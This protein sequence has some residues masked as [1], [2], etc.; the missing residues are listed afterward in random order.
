[1]LRKEQNDL[2]TQ[3]G[4][5]TP[6]GQMFRSHWLPALLAASCSSMGA[7]S[8]IRAR[9]EELAAVENPW[10]GAETYFVGELHGGG[11]PVLVIDDP[12]ECS[13]SGVHSP[14]T[15]V[16]ASSGTPCSTP[17]VPSRSTPRIRANSRG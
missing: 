16:T 17:M 9:S 6:M 7:S 4:H 15:V 1:M 12:D 5:G 10:V 14:C 8:A 3:T 13:S 2:L 11:V